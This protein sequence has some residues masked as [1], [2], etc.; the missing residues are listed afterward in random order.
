MK[1]LDTQLINAEGKYITKVHRKESEIP[2][3]CSSKIPKRYKRNTITTDLHRAENVASNM[4]EKIQIIRK[5]FIKADYP[6]P[7]FNSGI[8]QYNNKTKEQQIDNED[9]YIIPP[10]LFEKEKP[11]VLLKLPFCEKNEPKSKDFIKKF[12]KFTNT[13][14][15]LANSWKTR[16]IKSLFK[17]KD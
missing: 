6:R 9:D 10:Y 14:F 17:I 5:R 2:I 11:F 3:H 1:F 12:N 15:R 16:K 13:N 8:K 4:K 7:F